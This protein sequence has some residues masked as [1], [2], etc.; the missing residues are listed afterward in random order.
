MQ[1]ERET[2]SF[3]SMQSAHAQTFSLFSSFSL[4]LSRSASKVTI[5]S[6]R[7]ILLLIFLSELFFEIF[8]SKIFFSI[9]FLQFSFFTIMSHYY[10]ARAIARIQ[11]Q[12]FQL[13]SGEKYCI[14]LRRFHL[15]QFLLYTR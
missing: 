9:F 13:K 3:K 14:L 7:L 2:A 10:F 4:F 12:S 8:F 6:Q 15:S 5:V 11:M 1:C